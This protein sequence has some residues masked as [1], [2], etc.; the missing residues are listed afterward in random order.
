VL[1]DRRLAERLGR[2]AHASADLWTIS[3][4]EFARRLRALVEQVAGLGAPERDRE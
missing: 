1:T 2:N 4:E 3:P